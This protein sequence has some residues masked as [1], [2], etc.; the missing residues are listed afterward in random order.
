MKSDGIIQNLTGC[1][2]EQTLASEF[3]RK[4]LKTYYM[5][6]SEIWPSCSESDRYVQLICIEHSFELIWFL[7]VFLS[8]IMEGVLSPALF[9]WDFLNSWWIFFVFLWIL[10]TEETGS[11]PCKVCTFNIFLCSTSSRNGIVFTCVYHLIFEVVVALFHR[12]WL[13]KFVHISR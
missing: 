2:Q 12:K 8:G 10:S 13:L 4:C 7:F 3:V 1:L 6:L 5:Y 9:F 11:I